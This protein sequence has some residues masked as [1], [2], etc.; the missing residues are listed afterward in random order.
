MKDLR[1]RPPTAKKGMRTIDIVMWIFLV[2]IV[3]LGAFGL[4]LSLFILI[5]S[6]FMPD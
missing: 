3:A 2:P 5:A 4:L 6:I 1:K